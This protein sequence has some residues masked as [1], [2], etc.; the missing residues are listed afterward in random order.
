MVG[1]RPVPRALAW[2]VT[3]RAVDRYIQRHAP[4]LSF[5]S[6]KARILTELSGAMLLRQR[7]HRGDFRWLVPGLDVVAIVKED[8]GRVVVTI[9]PRRPEDL[10]PEEEGELIEAASKLPNVRL[11]DL[12]RAP[13]WVRADFIEAASAAPVAEPRMEAAP[14]VIP[15]PERAPMPPPPTSYVGRPPERHRAAVFALSPEERYTEDLKRELQ[16]AQIRQA[17]TREREKTERVRI[18]AES[19]NE[20]LKE[21]LRSALVALDLCTRTMAEMTEALGAEHVEGMLEVARKRAAKAGEARA[22][23]AIAV[24]A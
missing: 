1:A 3:N 5:A 7:T 20:R 10:T 8:S 19:N 2:V 9:E 23:N 21:A 14:V 15:E 17:E 6:A 24:K 22:Q 16:I 12:R 4:S 18:H 11:A 13:E